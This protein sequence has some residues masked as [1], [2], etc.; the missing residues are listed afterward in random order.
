MHGAMH[1][2][3]KGHSQRA[4]MHNIANDASQGPLAHKCVHHNHPRDL[5][6]HRHTHTHTPVRLRCLGCTP[7]PPEPPAAWLTPPRAGG[8]TRTM[9]P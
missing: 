8:H 6:A 7:T 1:G 2:A 3:P 4:C 5:S 9:P